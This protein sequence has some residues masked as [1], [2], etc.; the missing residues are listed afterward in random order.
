MHQW[1]LPSF[2]HLPFCLKLFQRT[3]TDFHH[4]ISALRLSQQ[5]VVLFVDLRRRHSLQDH[6]KHMIYLS[7][8]K[9][10][11]LKTLAKIWCFMPR[12][13]PWCPSVGGPNPTDA[14]IVATT[15]RFLSPGRRT[16]TDQSN[17]WSYF[18]ICCDEQPPLFTVVAFLG[19]ASCRQTWPNHHSLCHL[20]VLCPIWFGYR[21]K[22]AENFTL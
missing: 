7:N 21:E 5:M 6:C 17:L 12:T 1:R 13:L 18:A 19:S 2:R 11:R 9:H 14:C 16:V 22:E 8:R 3:K 20:M 4:R 10:W 15:N